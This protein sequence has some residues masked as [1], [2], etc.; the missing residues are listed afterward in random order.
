MDKM[1]DAGGKPVMGMA[2]KFYAVDSLDSLNKALDDIVQVV[3]FEGMATCDDS[4]Y[5]I[6]CPNPGDMCIRGMCQPNPCA[7]VTCSGSNYCYTDG[8]SPGSCVPA[9]KKACPKG[10]R[11]EMGHCIQDP[12]VAPCV[13]GFVC[14]GASKQCEPDPLCPPDRPARDQCKRPSQCQY[15]KCVDDPCVFIKC[16][17]QTHCVHWDGHCDLDP[18]TNGGGADMSTGPTD[19]SGSRGGCSAGADRQARGGSVLAGLLVMLLLLRQRR[20]PSPR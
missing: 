19:D 2:H 6:G 5:A 14:N 13:A 7:S 9:C 3:T 12:C 11:C 8:V 18:S 1:A 10:Y 4:C 16:P 15:G 17:A 20:R